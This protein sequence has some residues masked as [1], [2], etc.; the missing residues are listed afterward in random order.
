H[1]Q[2]WPAPTTPPNPAILP[3]V[4]VAADH[5]GIVWRQR[6]RIREQG[7][8]LLLVLA[9]RLAYVVVQDVLGRINGQVLTL[10]RQMHAL[11][12]KFVQEDG[13]CHQKI[14]LVRTIPSPFKRS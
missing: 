6:G 1:C 10:N 12:T 13:G 8:Q 4:R 9:D 11:G 3:P 2:R 7:E 5:A 14:S